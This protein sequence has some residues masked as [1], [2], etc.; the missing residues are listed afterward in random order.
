MQSPR[1]DLGNSSFSEARYA[2]KCV[3]QIYAA[4]LEPIQMGATMVMETNRNICCW[5]LL[6][7]CEFISQGTQEH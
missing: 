6:H 5:V 7:K 1:Q 3:N 2:E 4:M